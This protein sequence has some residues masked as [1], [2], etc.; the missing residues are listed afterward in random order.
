M[1]APLFNRDLHVHNGWLRVF[2]VFHLNL[3]FSSIEEERRAQVIERCYWPLL[4]L[5][6]KHHHIGIEISAFTLEEVNRL[7]PVW[8][9]TFRQMIAENKVELIGSGYSQ[10]IG[11][12]V[13]G[14][15]SAENLRIAG[16]IYRELLGAAPTVALVN[17]Q[18]F[19]AGLVENYLNAGYSA[20]LMDWDN[21][22]A[23]HP[24]WDIERQYLPQYAAGLD[25]RKIALLWTNTAAFQ[26]L[27]RFI[28]EDI[29]LETYLRFVRGRRAFSTRAMCL[30]ASDAEIF[31]FR[32]G[33]FKTEE[34][35]SADSAEWARMDKA[36]SAVTAEAGVNLIGPSHVLKLIDR[37]GGGNL[38]QL[39]SP[40]CPVPVKKQR[41]YNLARWAVTGRDNTAIN[42]ACQRIYQGMLAGSPSRADWKE[43]C[44]MWASD[45]RTHITQARWAGLCE[46]LEAAERKWSVPA[47]APITAPAAEP[48]TDR[49]INIETPFISARL[50]RRRG[51][52]IGRLRFDTNEH[53]I[54]GGLPHSYFDEIGLQAD[55]YT[56]DCVFEAPGEPKLTDL[57]WCEAR[58]ERTADG[59]AIAHARTDTPR[60]VIEKQMHFHG[61]ARRIDFDITFHW[62]TWEPGVLRLGHFTLLPDAFALDR[63]RLATNNGGGRENFSLHGSTIDHGAPVSFLVSS[64]H[65]L[66]MTEGWAEIG[67]D[68]TRLRI[69]VDRAT[70]PLLG[71]LT[72]RPAKRAGNSPSLFCQLQLSALELDDTR[73]PAAYR[74]GPRRFRF[75]ISAL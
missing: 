14:R 30:Y 55:W 18:A 52:A 54:I 63:L 61:D 51:L 3:A 25:G 60:G 59:G 74:Q 50:D 75:S 10:M 58:I 16:D 56:G 48:C 21:P 72:H 70:A 23:Q 6:K 1:N 69:E 19:S 44:Y 62:E 37:E 8:V 39:E 26:Q 17:E 2:A 32:P 47:P 40:A 31:D 46:R 34:K 35:L 53:A 29:S 41:K 15:V 4:R 9:E 22:S 67:D 66:G 57:E 73:K 64:S 24:E 27:Q 43:L 12:L 28:Y 11:P 5:A 71:M 65:G 20:L 49:H 33:R 7:D 68:R 36:L 42:A 38:L 45:F 13:P